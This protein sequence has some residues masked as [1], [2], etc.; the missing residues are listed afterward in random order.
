MSSARERYVL[1][2]LAERRKRESVG[3]LLVT[4]TAQKQSTQQGTLRQSRYSRQYG[5]VTSHV[6][7][8]QSDVRVGSMCISMRLHKREEGAS[9]NLTRIPCSYNQPETF[10]DLGHQSI[11][12]SI[13][14]ATRRINATEKTT[15]DQDEIRAEPKSNIS[16]AVPMFVHS[17]LLE[18][19]QIKILIIHHQIRDNQTPCLHLC[20]GHLSSRLLLPLR[21]DDICWYVEE[22]PLPSTQAM[23]MFLLL[24]ISVLRSSHGATC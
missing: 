2:V 13:T 1:I 24:I 17:I 16:P 8:E 11:N 3:V 23:L 10:T 9:T 22:H 7:S 21:E 4:M 6:T 12:Q 18:E 15:L 20:H 19:R 5:S 14:M